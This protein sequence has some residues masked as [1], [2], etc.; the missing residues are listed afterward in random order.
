[1]SIP[2]IGKDPSTINV[3]IG[4][5]DDKWT[6]G[7]LYTY[8]GDLYRC[9]KFL[10]AVTYKAGQAVCWAD[11]TLAYVSNDRSGGTSIGTGVTA[12]AGIVKRVMTQNYKGFIQVS[13]IC[14]VEG[15][16][17]VAADEAVVL[18]SADGK[19]DTM[20]AGEEHQVLGISLDADSTSNDPLATSALC[21]VRLKGLV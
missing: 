7:R 12:A 9:V 20:A 10:D 18:D 16:G 2:S 19:V 14:L 21:H 15:D 1:M 13:G 4:S 5:R 17:S 6:L 3:E 8:G 11:A